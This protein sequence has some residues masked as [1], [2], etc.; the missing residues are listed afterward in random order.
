MSYLTLSKDG[1]VLAEATQQTYIDQMIKAYADAITEIETMLAKAYATIGSADPKQ[2]YAEMLK[3]DRLAKLK[4]EIITAYNAAATKAGKATIKGLSSVME[5][6]YSRQLYLGNWLAETLNPIPINPN[7]VKYAVTGNVSY[8]T[9]IQKSWGDMSLYSPQ[10]GTLSDLLKN[11][12]AEDLNKIIKTINNSLI[13]GKPYTETTKAIKEIIG[14]Y[15]KKAG[16]EAASGAMY[17]AV[18][19]ARTEGAR[20][21]NAA[22]LASG[23]QLEAQGF[24]TQKQ[25]VA[26]LDSKTRVS[27][28]GLDG[29][30]RDLDKDFNSSISSGQAPGQMGAAA[31][32]IQCRCATINIIDGEEPEIRRARNPETKQNA[33]ISWTSYPEWR[34]TL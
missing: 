26:T 2:Y 14:T 17:K 12:A 8:W 22:A 33:V 4:K 24:E 16:K 25:W 31:D 9:K 3:Y 18:R 21:M 7:V 15:S 32:N 6:N 34:K 28:Q 13:T 20:V 29:Q 19:I 10:T 5:E 11:G 23:N 27:H 1:Y 30:L